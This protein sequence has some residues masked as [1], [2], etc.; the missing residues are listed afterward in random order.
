LE[1]G[2]LAEVDAA[3]G[4]GGFDGAVEAWGEDGAGWMLVGALVGALV[5]KV[6]RV[7]MRR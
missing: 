3:V 5:A 4:F 6:R 7:I 2:V 1:V